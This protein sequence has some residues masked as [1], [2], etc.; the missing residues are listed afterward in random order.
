MTGLLM[1]LTVPTVIAAVDLTNISKTKEDVQSRLDSALIAATRFD[2]LAAAN[3]SGEIEDRGQRFLLNALKS[4]GI[5]TTG[6]TSTFEYDEDQNV[7]RGSVEII[8]PTIFAGKVLNLD[9]LNIT[10][11]IVPRE[12]I[13]LEIALSLDVSGSM[14]WAIDSDIIAPVGSRRIDALKEGVVSLVTVFDENPLVTARMSII[15]YS[16]SVNLSQTTEATA[17]IDATNPVWATERAERAGT[18]K[19]KI[20]KKPP[21]QSKRTELK[22]VG[23]PTASVL[24]LSSTEQAVAYI[25]SVEPHGGTAGHIGAE[26]AFYSLLPDWN[27][28]WNHPDGEPGA[29]DSSTRKILVIMTDGDF[30]VTQTDEMTIDDAYDVFQDVCRAARDDGVSI[31][32]VGLKASDN[33]DEQLTEC[34]GSEENYFP[35]SNR[36]AI[37]DAFKEIGEKA[38]RMR[39]SK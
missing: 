9:R 17:S 22:A 30:T 14:G 6:L 23:S 36:A 3:D 33:T 7:M 21:S 2:D 16:A 39:I 29:L 5:D 35:V 20:S 34:A 28:V 15:P 32:T 26:W 31:Y 11:E 18:G 4:A 24:P 10:S 8:A 27:E 12:R 1:T 37:T 25:S 38:T 13:D 19:Y